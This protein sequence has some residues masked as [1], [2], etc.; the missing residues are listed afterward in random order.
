M[1]YTKSEPKHPTTRRTI[2]GRMNSTTQ[3]QYAR[4]LPARILQ[5]NTGKSLTAFQVMQ[6]AITDTGANILLVQEPPL[7]NGTPPPLDDFHCFPS[8][9]QACQTVT[10]IRKN[11]FKSTLVISDPHADFLVVSLTLHSKYHKPPTINIANY[12]NRLQN[13]NWRTR[14]QPTHSLDTLFHE[15][16]TLADLVAGD[17]NKH[18]PR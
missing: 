5:Y 15:I 14:D 16:F 6:A 2:Y 8:Y 1:K 12:D 11:A 4:C 3:Q 9:K 10:Y 18:H 13:R 17:M 7:L